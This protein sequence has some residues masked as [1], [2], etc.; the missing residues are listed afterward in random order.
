[1]FKELISQALVEKISGWRHSGFSVH[2]QVRTETREEAERVDKY[3]IRPFLSLQRLSFD[4]KEGK[5]TYQY[6]K[7]GEE[8]ERVDYL[9]FIARVTSHIPDKGRVTIRYFGL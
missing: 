5:L 2:S 3:M 1:L 4:E 7:E 6:G 9:E 8:L